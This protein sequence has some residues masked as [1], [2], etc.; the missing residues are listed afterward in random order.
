VRGWWRSPLIIIPGG[1]AGFVALIMLAALGVSLANLNQANAACTLDPPAGSGPLA[2]A[3]IPP[4]FLPYFEGASSYFQLGGDGWAYLAALNYAE[5]RFDSPG[6]GVF[7]GSNPAGAAGPMQIGIGGAAT[8]NWDTY[9]PDIP[10]SLPGGTEPPSVYNEADAVYAAGAKLRNDGAPADWLAALTAWNNYPPEIQEVTSLV[11]QYTQAPATGGTLAGAGAGLTVSPTAAGSCAPVSGPS[12]PGAAAQ[13]LPDG[14]AA[15]PTDAPAQV[16]EAIAAGNRIIDTSYST[17]RDPNMLSTVMSSYDC[18]GSTDYVLYNAGLSS[19]QVDV[20]GGI[21][22]DSTLLESYGTPGAGQ[23]ITVF[24]SAG[25]AFI[26]VAGVVLDTS[27]YA[28]TAPAG[29]GPRWQPASI[30]PGQLADGNVW[31]QRH[32]AGL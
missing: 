9:K 8:D 17:E 15:I 27:H 16:Q 25:H 13:I 28:P 24:A 23:W 4:Q 5:S 7:A 10:A 32:P 21:A 29:T 11:A 3:G 1:A 18:S 22:G 20:G 6:A 31:T 26:E 2:V 19:P 14:T 12:V 30:L